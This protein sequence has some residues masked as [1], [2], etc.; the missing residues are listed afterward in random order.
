MAT[1]R[2]IMQTDL[3]T[4]VPTATVAQAAELMGSHSV[5]SALVVTDGVLVG[6]FTDRDIISALLESALGRDDPVERWMTRQPRTIGPE[7][8]VEEARRLML[9]EGIRH[10]PVTQ[11][12]NRPIGVL[13]MQDL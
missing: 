4:V 9:A 3:V 6:I 7:A 12:T 1:V 11:E 13:S 8:P 5:G 2:A 10:L